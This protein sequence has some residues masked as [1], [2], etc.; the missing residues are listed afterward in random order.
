ME[1]IFARN[2][3]VHVEDALAL[4]K[5]SA[6]YAQMSATLLS[7]KETDVVFALEIQPAH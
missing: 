4:K 3:I 7:L 2:A 1:K 6:P 5:T